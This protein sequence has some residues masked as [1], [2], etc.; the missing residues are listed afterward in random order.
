MH[1]AQISYSLRCSNQT[2][3]SYAVCAGSLQGG[4]C[5]DCASSRGE[6]WI[7]QKEVS[8]RGITGHFE[9]VVYRLQR[10]VVSI[11]SNV[12]YPCRWNDAKNPLYHSETGS[13]NRD[14]RKLLT[15]DV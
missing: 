5:G 14:E 3:K 2:E 10:A 12:P 11:E 1:L 13:Q 7:E 15:R 9:V 6:H 4:N 8:L